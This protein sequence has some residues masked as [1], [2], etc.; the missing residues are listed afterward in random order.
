MEAA[1]L[2]MPTVIRIK[3]HTYAWGHVHTHTLFLWN[4]FLL[5]WLVGHGD[6]VK[7]RFFSLGSLWR[8]EADWIRMLCP[9][10]YFLH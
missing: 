10:A 5:Y 6:S 8:L 9:G 1:D 4:D 2:C 3:T 7:S